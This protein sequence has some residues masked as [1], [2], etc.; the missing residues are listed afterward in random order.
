MGNG[1]LVFWRQLAHDL[2]A[3]RGAGAVEERVAGRAGQ[4]RAGRDLAIAMAEGA[5]RTR[6]AAAAAPHERVWFGLESGRV[7]WAASGQLAAA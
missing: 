5:T 6:L 7:E 1:T 4:G 2:H 3:A